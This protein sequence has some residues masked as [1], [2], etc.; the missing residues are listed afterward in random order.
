M[1]YTHYWNGTRAF[2]K[3]EWAEITLAANRILATTRVPLEDR[4]INDQHI[5]LNG[6]GEDGHETFRLTRHPDDFDFCKT[7]RKPYDAVVTA[8]L[9]AAARHGKDAIQVSSDGS[10]KEWK[11][12]LTLVTA[13]C[14]RGFVVPASVGE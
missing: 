12:G 11:P 9:I 3:H 14:G 4:E 2:T 8:I 6:V 13:A 7:A 10:P 5:N 1:G